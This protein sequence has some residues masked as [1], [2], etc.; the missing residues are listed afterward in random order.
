MVE[1]LSSFVVDV[2]YLSDPLIDSLCLAGP[3]TGSNGHE[4]EAQK[5]VK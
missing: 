2:T 4:Y 1:S 5:L 3:T